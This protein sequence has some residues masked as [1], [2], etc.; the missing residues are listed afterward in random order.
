MELSKPL[1]TER[2]RIRAMLPIA[3]PAALMME[4]MFITL[5]FFLANR[6]LRAI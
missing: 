1:Y 2:I 4:I 5:C 3:I 6:Y